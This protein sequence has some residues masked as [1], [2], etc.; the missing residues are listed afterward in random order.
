[1]IVSYRSRTRQSCLCP[2]AP[3]YPSSSF[4]LRVMEISHERREGV[5]NLSSVERVILT[6]QTRCHPTVINPTIDRCVS[7][8]ARGE[9]SWPT[10][11]NGHQAASDI[12]RQQNATTC[13]ASL[14]TP[15]PLVSNW[16]VP[17]PGSATDVLV[18]PSA[19]RPYD[20]RRAG[21]SADSLKYTVSS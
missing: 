20:S 17:L 13:G 18:V 2:I 9:Y 8:G 7:M 11:S 15:P 5:Q 21:R 3:V 1:M 10:G 19:L 14:E 16:G 6:S 4:I 12:R